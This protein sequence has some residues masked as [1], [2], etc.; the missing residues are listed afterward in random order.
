MLW[1]LFLV[2]AIAEHISLRA[3]KD[4]PNIIIFFVGDLG[5]GD[6]GFNGHPTTVT[7]NIDKLA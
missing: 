7:P 2:G 5:Y 6:V 3:A 4:K 1:L